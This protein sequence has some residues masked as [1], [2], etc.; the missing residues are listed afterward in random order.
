[1]VEESM[2][3]ERLQQVRD[4][5]WVNQMEAVCITVI[6]RGSRDAVFE[7][8][9]VDADSE[10]RAIFATAE[11][12]QSEDREVVQV[13]RSGEHLLVVEPNGFAGS[14]PE[15]LLPMVQ[16]HDAVSVYWNVN[17]NMRVVIVDNG[18]VGTRI[19]PAALRRW[20]PA[21]ARGGWPRLR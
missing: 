19:R 18:D 5:S 16:D 1:L 15:T 14:L 4:Y 11:G 13:W 10:H 3:T 7:V 12:E 2:A 6:F 9:G 17:A 21:F 8:L 20:R